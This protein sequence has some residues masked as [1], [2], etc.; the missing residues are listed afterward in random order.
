VGTNLQ[1]RYKVPVISQAP[2]K[3]SLLKDCTFLKGYN[4]CLEKWESQ[5]AI[6]KGGCSSNGVSLAITKK[7]KNSSN[8]NTN[9][10]IAGWPAYCNSY[11][12]NYFEN[13]TAGLNHWTWLM[14]KAE[15]RNNAGSVT[16]RSADPQDVPEIRKRNFAVGGDEDLDALLE[17]LKYGRQSFKDLIP[18]D[19]RFEEVWP[20]SHV[21]TDA[22]LRDF[23]RHEAWGHH[24]S[25]TCP[26]GAEDDANVVLDGNFKVRGVDGLRVVDASSFPKIPGTYLALP[27]HMISEKAS[28][29]ILA[30]VHP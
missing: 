4:P 30:D 1:D 3:L 27:I 7:A 11:Y 21:K 23:A 16:L 15:F 29:V 18:L 10:L 2:S 13:A 5:P 17:G 28:D 12:P 26:I 25:C 8:G 24:A 20:G 9:L 22:Q 14:L 19:G 6:N